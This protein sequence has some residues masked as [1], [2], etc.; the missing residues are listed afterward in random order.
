MVGL[1]GSLM[2]GV[3]DRMIAVLLY[4]LMVGLFGRSGGRSAGQPDG[5]SLW[6]PNGRSIG[7]PDGRPAKQ[8][9]GK[10]AKQPDG[11]PVGQSVLFTE[12]RLENS[13]Y[14]KSI[15]K[16]HWK[17]AGVDVMYCWVCEDI[18]KKK[19]QNVELVVGRQRG[20]R[21]VLTEWKYIYTAEIVLI[22]KRNILQETCDV[23]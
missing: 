17:F 23:L 11:M 18:R 7:Q 19:F 9:D 6:E 21:S 10:P 4:S 1:V 22:I 3:L 5:R 8:P 20:W 2:S 12:S 16:F 15:C 14:N 13:P